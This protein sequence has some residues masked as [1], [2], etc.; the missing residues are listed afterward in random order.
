MIKRNVTINN[1][2]GL[3]ARAAAQFVS[4]AARFGSSIKL[5]YKDRTVDGK[6]IM[7]IM[8]LAAGRGAELE[9]TVEGSDEQDAVDALITLIDSQ[10]GEEE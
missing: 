8:I 1:K 9:M 3:H 10:F 4:T 2:L 6:S 5:S 7:G